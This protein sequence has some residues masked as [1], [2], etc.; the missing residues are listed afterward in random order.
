VSDVA[1]ADNSLIPAD[2]SYDC[3]AQT[4]FRFL[5]SLGNPVELSRPSIISQTQAFYQVTAIGC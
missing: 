2:M 5:H 4:W 3:I 1:D